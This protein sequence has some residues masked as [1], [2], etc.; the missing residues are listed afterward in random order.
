MKIITLLVMLFVG[1]FSGVTQAQ[2]S[3]LEKSLLW[4][5]SGN[6]LEKPSYLY[7]TIHMICKEDFKIT[8]KTMKA[9]DRS[10]QLVLEVDMF[11]PDSAAIIEEVMRADIPLSKKLSPEEYTTV[12]SLTRLKLSIPL[13]QFDH[14]KLAVVMSFLSLK[15]LPCVQPTSYEMAFTE[16][17][18]EKQLPLATLEG[19][20]EQFGFITSAY[21]DEQMITEMKRFDSVSMKENELVEKY[22]AEDISAI[23]AQVIAGLEDKNTIYWMLERRNNNWAIKMPDMMK[24]KSCFFAVGAGHLGGPGGIIALLRK[25]GYSVEPVM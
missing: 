18:K 15:L 25:K 7:G 13:Q 8:S 17:A 6:G 23:F 4:E 20:K 22:K 10:S 14:F 21:S 1:F 11:H 5:I 9:F 3:P 16:M 19:L 2:Q 24:G 12:D